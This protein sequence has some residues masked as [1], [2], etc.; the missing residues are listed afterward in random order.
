MD[1]I[2]ATSVEIRTITITAHVH[3]LSRYACR[4]CSVTHNA[5]ALRLGVEFSCADFD[6]AFGCRVRT[7]VVSE[8]DRGRLKA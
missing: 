5:D 7:W 3:S 8:V 6:L 4:W 2:Q 1:H